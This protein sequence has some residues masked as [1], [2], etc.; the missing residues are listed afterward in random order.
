[1]L[2]EFLNRWPALRGLVDFVYPPLCSGCGAYT[3]AVGAICDC[4]VAQIDWLESPIPLTDIDFRPTASDNTGTPDSFPLFAAG[5][6]ANP[7]NQI[8][9]NFKFKGVTVPAESIAARV[10]DMFGEKIHKLAPAVLVPIP[11]HPSREYV[12]GYNQATIFATELA[13]RLELSV[14][15]SLLYRI[16]KRRPQAKLKKHRRLSNIKSVFEVD[17]SSEADQPV[18][19]VILVDDVVT[20]G[21]TMFEARRCLMRVGYQVVGGISMAHAV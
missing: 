13:R 19:R 7:L 21:Q 9:I 15:E 1:M 17:L 12:R 8:V 4:C 16:K 5:A 10:V 6:Y 20:S 3:E 18:D 14:N 2:T 11:L